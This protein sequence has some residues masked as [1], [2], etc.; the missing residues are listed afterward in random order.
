MNPVFEY[1]DGFAPTRAVSSNLIYGTKKKNL[2]NVCIMIP[3]Y[4]RADTL[5][6]SLLSAINQVNFSPYEIIV[7]DNDADVDPATDK[8]MKRITN[9]YDNVLY[10]R[11]EKNI[12]MVG[13]WN[14]C[15]E[16]S[17]SEVFCILHD[18]DQIFPDYLEQLLPI[19]NSVEFGAI[20]V[21]NRAFYFSDGGEKQGANDRFKRIIVKMRGNRLIP[22][23]LKDAVTNMRPSPTACLYNKRACMEIGG[24]SFDFIGEGQLSDNVFFC[25]MRKQ[26]PVYVCPQILALRGIGDNDSYRAVY[27]VVVG[28]YELNQIIIEEDS[29][30]HKRLYHWL[31]K[32]T[33]CELIE[34]YEK[35]YQIEMDENLLCQRLHITAEELKINKSVVKVTRI[36]LWIWAC[37]RQDPRKKLIKSN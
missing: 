15:I 10:Y 36:L 14:R 16:L 29:I 25:R 27:D 2:P 6:V 22:F 4:R 1:Q 7:I 23:Y 28:D 30:K 20:G 37:C 8:L 31:A 32:C 19:A 13:N 11:N 33:V 34:S 24:F 21:F 12:G 5:E 26:W 17:R 3:T 9:Q 35:S 18:D